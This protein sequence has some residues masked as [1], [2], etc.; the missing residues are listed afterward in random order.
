MGAV[1]V[2]PADPPTK[3]RISEPATSGL[4]CHRG[5]LERPL[6]VRRTTCGV[7]SLPATPSDHPFE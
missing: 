5:D 6:R 2:R 7:G 3:A 1:P 4:G